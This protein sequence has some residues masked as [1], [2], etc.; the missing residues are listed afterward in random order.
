MYANRPLNLLGQFTVRATRFYKPV[1]QCDMCIRSSHDIPYSLVIRYTSDTSALHLKVPV[2]RIH[3][4]QTLSIQAHLDYKRMPLK[5]ACIPPE[6]SFQN[7][8]RILLLSTV[9]L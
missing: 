8:L 2:L 7:N 3:P 9:Y 6:C 4:A 5:L 1:P